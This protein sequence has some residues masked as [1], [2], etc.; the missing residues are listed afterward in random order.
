MRTILEIKKEDKESWKALSD[1][2]KVNAFIMNFLKNELI[3]IINIIK[4]DV[5]VKILNEN[6]KSNARKLQSNRNL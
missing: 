5:F 2:Q 1:Q 3:K 4:V 6:E